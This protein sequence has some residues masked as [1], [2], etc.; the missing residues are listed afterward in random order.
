M[1]YQ[2]RVRTITAH[3]NRFLRQYERPKHLDE[4]TALMEIRDMAD[5]MN[6]L[7]SASS[8][9]S[10]LEERVDAAL[11]TLRR[12][13]TQR[14]WPTV[15]HIVKAMQAAQSKSITNQQKTPDEWSLDPIQINADRMNAGEPVGDN[16][17]YGRLAI[18]LMASGKVD[19]QTMRKYRSALYFKAKDVGGEEYAAKREAVYL[20]RQADA[21][22]FQ[23]ESGERTMRSS[24]I[25]QEA[26]FAP[27][28][29]G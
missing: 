2:E 1:Q 13:Y 29:F 27:K 9:A 17:I 15:G 25:M 3:L 23:A 19:K 20:E 16:W 12:D 11:R 10:A 7:I 4:N 6:N 26:G 24:D 28:R 8:Q 5:E 22:R 14:T 21:E 18:N